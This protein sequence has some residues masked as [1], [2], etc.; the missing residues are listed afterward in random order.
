MS[1][2]TSRCGDEAEKTGNVS[3]YHEEQWRSTVWADGNNA[4]LVQGAR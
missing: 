4:F 1:E 3:R 2:K